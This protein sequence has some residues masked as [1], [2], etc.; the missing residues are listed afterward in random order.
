VTAENEV[1]VPFQKE[2]VKDAPRIEAGG[3]LSPDQERQLWEHYGRSDYDEW[4]GED[5]VEDENAPV[6]VGVRLRRVIV[7]A[8]STTDPDQPTGRRS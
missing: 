8:P 4:K 5:D 3:E 6:I 1:Q 7:V 2:Q